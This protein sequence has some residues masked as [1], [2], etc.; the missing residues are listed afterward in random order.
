MNKI[1]HHQ[2]FSVYQGDD[3]LLPSLFGEGLGV[4]LYLLQPTL[5]FTPIQSTSSKY[6]TNK[7]TFILFNFDRFVYPE[8]YSYICNIYVINSKQY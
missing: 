4:R 3:M 7:P 6:L 8:I 1:I 2:P 5:H